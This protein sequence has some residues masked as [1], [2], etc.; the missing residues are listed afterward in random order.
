MDSALS[1]V[2]LNVSA[3]SVIPLDFA[4]LQMSQTQA[5]ALQMVEHMMLVVRYAVILESTTAPR[6]Q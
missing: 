3:P 4:L 6:A 5:L 2:E 1:L